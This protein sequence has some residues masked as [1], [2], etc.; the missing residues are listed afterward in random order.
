[1]GVNKKGFTLIELLVVIAIIGILAAILLPAL[2][3][4]REMARRSSCQNNLKQLGLV[5]KMYANESEGGMYPPI[6]EAKGYPGVNCSARLPN[7]ELPPRGTGNPAFMFFIPAVY[8]EYMSDPDLLVCPSDSDPPL[9]RNP[10]TGEPWIHLPCDESSMMRYNWQAGGWAGTDE[11]YFYFGWV[12]D[13]AEGKY[14]EIDLG[15]LVS[16]FEGQMGSGQIVG[17]LLHI[18]TLNGTF[19]EEMSKCN[20]D[21]YL[22]F[23]PM[24]ADQV[25]GCGNGASDT[26]YR[27]REGIERFMITDINN[28]AASSLAQSNIAIIADGVSTDV[29]QFNHVPGGINSLYLDGH[30]EFIKYP[31]KDFGSISMA[32][33]YGA[34]G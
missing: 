2:A 8:P 27:L 33:I 21:I 3:R 23:L 18:M 4:A 25:A 30:V 20:A 26:I 28:P 13:D 9:V 12:V 1:M 29:S 31:G 7:A 15:G 16:G 32:Q 5:L 34:V 22:P 17:I 10:V 19:D 24:Y 14:G 6:A 11:C